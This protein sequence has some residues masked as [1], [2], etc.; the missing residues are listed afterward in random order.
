VGQA[1]VI[2]DDEH[3]H[4]HSMSPDGHSGVTIGVTDPAPS[5]AYNGAMNT[6]RLSRPLATAG[7]VGLTAMSVAAC[8]GAKKPPSSGSVSGHGSTNSA[9]QSAYRYSSCMRSH[10]VSAFQ[11]PK[12]HQSG[13]S[14]SVGF[15]VDPQ[16]TGAPAFKSAQRACAHILPGP[17]GAPSAAE[18]HAHEQAFLAFA[19][20]MRK[21]GFPRFPDPN[22]QGRLTPAMLSA[23][24][25]NLQQPAIKPAAY[26][27]VSVTHGIVTRA[28]I[29]QA[30]ANP[31]GSGSQSG[32]GG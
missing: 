7:V 10:G 25:I 12:V 30:I 27:C 1:F 24:G 5:G 6:R 18:Q 31:N 16:I 8:G 19:A 9:I 14:L 23:A 22:G 32:S 28:D 13:N 20:C 29:N 4:R 21:H 2:L 3:S 26:T 15:R 17:T 11:D